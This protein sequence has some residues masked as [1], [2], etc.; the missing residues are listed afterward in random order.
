MIELGRFT[1]PYDTC[2]YLGDRPARS[3]FRLVVDLS[4][5]EYDELLAAGWRRF[6]SIVFQP[7][8]EPCHECVPIRVVVE[9]FRPSRSQRRVLRRNADIEVEVGEPCADEERLGLYER[10][11]LE[12]EARRGWAPTRMTVSAYEESFVHNAVATLEFRY[13]LA[14]RLVAIAYVGEAADALNSIYAFSDPRVL[15]RGLG[16]F[17]VLREIEEARRRGKRHLYLG[18]LVDGCRSMEYKAAFRPYELRRGDDWVD[19]G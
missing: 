16:N 9:R 13:R 15:H 6:G 17:D 14:R 10:H 1:S 8:C 11:H 3:V 4:P 12:R 5:H 7:R 2:P 19:A 18:F